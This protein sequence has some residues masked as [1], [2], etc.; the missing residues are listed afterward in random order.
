MQINPGDHDLVIAGGLV[1]SP[2][3]AGWLGNVNVL[4]TTISLL[5][6][7]ALGL[8]RLWLAWHDSKGR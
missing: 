3:W 5:V 7:L 2:A 8:S 1:S 6:G 4:L